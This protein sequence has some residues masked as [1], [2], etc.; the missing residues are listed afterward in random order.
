MTVGAKHALRREAVMAELRGV[1]G[2]AA[3]CAAL[4]GLALGPAPRDAP[5][6]QGMTATARPLIVRPLVFE[7]NAGQSAECVRFLARGGGGTAWLT[8]DAAVLALP[9][10]P[11]AIRAVGA[12]TPPAI[13]PEAKLP[14][15]AD[16]LL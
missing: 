8:D 14:G 9:R 11:L 12:R 1:A 16:Y 3:A 2:V 5:A 15:Q 13:E 10:G 4:T 6:P 7:A